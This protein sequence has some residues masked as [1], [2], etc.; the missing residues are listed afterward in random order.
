MKDNDTR[1]IQFP[2]IDGRSSGDAKAQRGPVHG[3]YNDT[4]MFGGI[5]C[6]AAQMRLDDV[7]PVQERQLSIG[8][9][10][11]LF[12]SPSLVSCHLHE[13]S[14]SEYLTL[15]FANCARASRAVT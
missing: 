11:D 2:R 5:V 8:L 15:Y 13:K 3:Q 10:P 14:G 1:R 6:D 12:E 7:V 4:G 9:D